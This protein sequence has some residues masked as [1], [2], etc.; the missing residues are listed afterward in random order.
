MTWSPAL[1][2]ENNVVEIAKKFADKIFFAHI[3]NVKKEYDGSFQESDHLDGD[4]NIPELLSV[5]LKE[6]E[7]RKKNKNVEFEIPFRPDHGHKIL[8][9]FNSNTH[10]GYPLLGRMKG[11]S[12]LRGVIA[13]LKNCIERNNT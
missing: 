3:R 2:C 8:N 13:S 6:E 1:K 10:P 7:R 9:D 11:L 4:S 12:E 5:L